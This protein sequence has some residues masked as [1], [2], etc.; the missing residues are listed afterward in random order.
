MDH[1]PRLALIELLHRDGRPPHYVDV[2]AWPFS[3]GRALDNDLVLDDPHVAAHHATLDRAEDG[4]VLLRLG[5]TLNGASM[6]ERRLVAGESA[7]LDAGE[8][9]FQLGSTRLR[10]RLPQQALAPER[11]LP[12]TA[13]PAWVTA[14]LLLALAVL[15]YWPAWLRADPGRD[16][17]EWVPMLLALPLGVALWCLLWALASKLFQHRFDFWGHL[18]VLS[19]VLAPLIALDLLLPQLGASLS[20]PWLWQAAQWLV[21]AGLAV[22]GWQH[23]QLV[24][25][26]RPL[27]LALVCLGLLVLGVVPGLVRHQRQF[28][29]LNDSA[30][31]ATLPLPAWRWHQAGTV[32][33]LVTDAKAL[34]PTMKARVEA[35]RK[36]A[37]TEDGD[38][39]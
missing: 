26:S 6:G 1:T 19:R 11:P 38:A 21:P 35:A 22:L 23:A 34:E 27:T 10:L 15:I 33:Q 39:D 28:E 4:T 25:G 32:E 31:M 9:S 7:T 20:W 2:P 30:Y 16:P 18:V 13:Q 36:E 17:S 8:G 12:A 3:M 5:E 37:S 14:A 24:V 29:R